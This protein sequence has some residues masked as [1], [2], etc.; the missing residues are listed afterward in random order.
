MRN[1]KKS[2]TEQINWS[3]NP[4][5]RLLFQTLKKRENREVLR[6]FGGPGRLGRGRAGRWE[7]FDMNDFNI[8]SPSVLIFQNPSSYTVRSG[9][10][11]DF[12]ACL[13]KVATN[14]SITM[15]VSNGSVVVIPVLH[16]HDG[17]GLKPGD[18]LTKELV[19]TVYKIDVAF[20][21]NH[22]KPKPQ[23]LTP[24]I[25]RQ[26]NVSVLTSVDNKL[27]RKKRQCV[28]SGNFR[29][30]YAGRGNFSKK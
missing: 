11:R 3:W 6:C 20:V 13:L 26:A 30:K 12:L 1:S 7:R 9:I 10:I 4:D 23:E 27:T 16:S 14:N 22:P 25:L 5:V 24:N 2:L 29:Q 17:M 19:G 28:G 21:K 18:P 15:L 8:P